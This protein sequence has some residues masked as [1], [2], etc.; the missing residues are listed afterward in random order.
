FDNTSEVDL[1]AADASN[2]LRRDI[3]DNNSTAAYVATWKADNG[4]TKYIHISGSPTLNGKT[5]AQFTKDEELV[6]AWNANS[7][8]I[9]DLTGVLKVGDLVL[10]KINDSRAGVNPYYLVAINDVIITPANDL[11]DY[12]SFRYKN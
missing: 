10:V 4:T 12:V 1:S 8:K 3:L 6:A 2:K 5:Y 9:S 7:G 11:K